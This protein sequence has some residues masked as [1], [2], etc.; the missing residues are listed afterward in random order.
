MKLDAGDGALLDGCDDA[1]VVIGDGDDDALV[2]RLDREAV[3]EV[4]VLP[5]EA[6]RR[7]PT[8]A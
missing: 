7:A 5:V 4:D 3:R 1:A 2:R 6:R 8:A